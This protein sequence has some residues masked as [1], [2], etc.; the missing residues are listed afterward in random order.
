M[1][2]VNRS[3][4]KANKDTKVWAKNALMN[5]KNSKVMI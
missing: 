1:D 2:N 3:V 4:H 5:G